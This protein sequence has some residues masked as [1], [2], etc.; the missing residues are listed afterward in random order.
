MCPHCTRGARAGAGPAR[1]VELRI[2]HEPCYRPACMTTRSVAWLGLLPCW[3]LLGP[4]RRRTIDSAPPIPRPDRQRAV[5]RRRQRSG[6]L[7]HAYTPLS[8]ADVEAR[9]R[10]RVAHGS[11]TTVPR[12]IV[13]DCSEASGT[14]W[15]GLGRGGPFQQR[16]RQVTLTGFGEFDDPGMRSAT[17]GTV[18]STSARTHQLPV[19]R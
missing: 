9:S 18:V 11:R 15:I 7:L 12:R 13:G 19:R 10:T 8:F 5:W 2:W 16:R 1:T 14:Q 4:V 17:T 3:L 6:G